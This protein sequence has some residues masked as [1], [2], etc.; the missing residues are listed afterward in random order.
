M[1]REIARP[2]REDIRNRLTD[3]GFK[4]EPLIVRRRQV[5]RLD[6][7]ERD[8][9]VRAGNRVA[10][11]LRRITKIDRVLLGEAAD[12]VFDIDVLE[13]DG[14]RKAGKEPRLQHNADLTV[15]GFF[16]L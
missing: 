5:E 14:E 15:V 16:R 1:E 13:I 12:R 2:A 9:S 3:A 10:E 6:V 7:Y 4:I 8:D 11:L